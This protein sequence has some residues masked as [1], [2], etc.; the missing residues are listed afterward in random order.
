MSAPTLERPPK[1]LILGEAAAV[2]TQRWVQ[3]FRDTG[4]T[5]RW[6]SF[7]PIPDGCGADQIPQNTGW[8]ALAI[9]R[10]RTY[11]RNQIDQ[12]HPDII[13]AL[14]L[15][16]YG[17]LG[18]LAKRRPLAVSAWGSDVLLAPR[19]S[20]LHRWRIAHVLRRAD[21][22]FC[23]ADILAEQMTKLGAA[24]QRIR[25][26]P[27]GVTDDWLE[28]YEQ[29]DRPPK[30]S[31][32]VITN[33]RLEPLYKVDTFIR[34]VREIEDKNP[35]GMQFTIVGEGSQRTDLTVLAQQLGVGDRIEFTGHLDESQL[36]K[37]MKTADIFVSCSASDGTSVSLLEAM[38]A[39]VY[40][41]VT[42]LPA[43]REW[44]TPGDTG[45][46]FPVGDHVRLAQTI[47]TVAGDHT[48]RQRA[49][50]AN[51]SL[52]KQRARWTDNMETVESD[53]LELMA[54]HAESRTSGGRRR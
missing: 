29:R 15:P 20:P 40:P 23:D 3:F 37:R 51:H 6:M 28:L 54:E 1:I 44:L 39:G 13:S 49:A 4:W 22:L 18:C 38:A 2:H 25:T 14:F 52:V 34:A 8:R 24:R 53:L 19:K 21:W 41:V 32:S 11:V 10:A 45:H 12:F 9:W 30:Q 17:W 26:V 33:R 27:L 47:Q 35:G 43:N 36:R 16:D 48:L 7:A 31:I 46:L 5:V 50:A 42:E